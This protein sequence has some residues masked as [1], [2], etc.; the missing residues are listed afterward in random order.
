MLIYVC[1]TLFLKNNKNENYIKLLTKVIFF[2]CYF[3][4]RFIPSA[5]RRIGKIFKEKLVEEGIKWSKVPSNMKEYYWEEFEVQFNA[6]SLFD[7]C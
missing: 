3:I 2:I 7:K 5:S 6:F 4:Y 1:I